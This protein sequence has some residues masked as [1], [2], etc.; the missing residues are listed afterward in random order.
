MFFLAI[1]VSSLHPLWLTVSK[2]KKINHY[3]HTPRHIY[4]AYF[5][6][7]HA[8]SPICPSRQPAFGSLN[9]AAQSQSVV[10][11]IR[12]ENRDAIEEQK[13]DKSRKATAAIHG[14]DPSRRGSEEL[15]IA[16]D[17]AR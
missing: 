17:T 15:S 12:E 1:F 8:N 6:D 13:A 7:L 2:L 9:K 16:V 14:F 10:P 5:S 3:S 11:C 4:G